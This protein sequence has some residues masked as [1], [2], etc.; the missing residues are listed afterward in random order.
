MNLS[1]IDWLIVA[2]AL[3]FLVASVQFS[4]SLMRSVTDYLAAGRSAGR[5]LLTVSSGLAGLGAITI[6]NELEINLLAGFSMAWWGLTMSVVI[7]LVYVSG[8]VRYRFRQTRV[9]T[10]AQFFETRYSRRFRI[11]SGI[12]CFFS[13]L[14]NF[15]I[16]PAVGARFFIYFCGLPHDFSV[17]GLSVATFPVLMIFLLS[18]SLY[19]VFVGGQVAIII[20]DFIQ[21]LFVNLV[22]LVIL[23]YFFFTVDT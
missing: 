3:I 6:V 13:G 4:K 2:G 21:G 12:L 15:S 11:F 9:L 1:T 10:L 18:L 23:V 17:L 19:F 22:F 14:I 5:Y 20:T 16:F 8:W 7:L